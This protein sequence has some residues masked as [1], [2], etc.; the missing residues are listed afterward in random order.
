[1]KKTRVAVN[2]F[3]IR[4]TP[5]SGRTYS[6]LSF[7]EIAKHAEDQINSNS[8]KKGYKDKEL[9]NIH[10]TRFEDPKILFDLDKNFSFSQ[11]SYSQ[12]KNN[13]NFASILENE[14]QK[15]KSFS[16]KI[17]FSSD[18]ISSDLYVKKLD[19]P[20]IVITSPV[21]KNENWRYWQNINLVSIK[22]IDNSD[23]SKSLFSFP[24]PFSF[25]TGDHGKIINHVKSWIDE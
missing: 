24:T 6:T 14:Y 8:F 15:K 2:D 16:F 22:D 23:Y 17:P 3:V 12:D 10:V 5:K 1:M 4:Q 21:A 19:P 20:N 18:L 11:A 13:T 25:Y 7:K 9:F